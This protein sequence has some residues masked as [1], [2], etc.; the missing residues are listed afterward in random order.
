MIYVTLD[1][2]AWLKL[3]HDVNQESLDDIGPFDE[4]LFW[5]EQGHL[6]LILPQNLRNEWE[7]HKERNIQAAKR[8]IGRSFQTGK[9]LLKSHPALATFY[10]PDRYEDFV[11]KRVA[12]IDKVFSTAE[13]APTTDAVILAAAK[14]SINQQAP[15]HKQDS[16]RDTINIVSLMDHIKSKGYGPCYF[17]SDNTKDFSDTEAKEK[18]HPDLI[19]NF[20]ESNLEYVYTARTL[21]YGKLK[22]QLPAYA[23]YLQE[24]RR[25]EEEDKL[26]L[27]Q[28]ELET[29]K[30][31][32][33]VEFL[34]NASF[35]DRVLAKKTMTSFEKKMLKELIDSHPSYMSYFLKKVG[36][37]N[38]V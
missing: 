36:N 10:Q 4:L 21:I 25:K 23:D 6:T 26:K 15:N 34:E 32:L 20:R 30:E 12:R 28:Q 2:D 27:Q 16:F 24:E 18:L 19:A 1:T 17:S 37:G 14:R 31:N 33:S 22:K 13:L 3:V 7:R 38:L 5:L 9:E 8:E 11:R 29:S 35:I